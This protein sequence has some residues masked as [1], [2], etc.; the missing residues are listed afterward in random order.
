MKT[1]LFIIS[2]LFA[3]SAVSAQTS[4]KVNVTTAGTLSDYI[5]TTECKSLT[6]LTVTGN[7]DAR[8]FAFM[9]DRLEVLADLDLSGSS[10]RAYQGTSGTV[11]GYE[12]TYNANEIPIYAFYNPFYDTYKYTL[13]SFKF[14]YLTSSIGYLAFYYCSSLTG[15]LTIPASVKQIL[16]YTFYG[17][18]SLTDF[19]VNTANTKFSS[20][21]GVLFNKN[22]DTL[23]VCPSGKAG[24]FSIPTTVKHISASAF[25]NTYNLTSITL[26]AGLK[27]IGTYGFCYS[28]GISGDLNL[29]STLTRVEY[30]AFYGCWNLTG[31]VTIPASLTEIGSYC[32][33]ESNNL[34]SFTVSSS[35]SKY[36]SR[37]GV[38]YSKNID[39]LFICP[40]TKAGTFTIP[41]SVKALGLYA[42]NNCTQLSGTMTITDNISFIGDGAFYKTTSLSNF[43]VSPANST[44]VAENGVLFSKDKSLLIACPPA[45]TGSYQMPLT[46]RKIGTLAFAFC[47]NLTGLMNIPA[48]VNKMGGYAFYGC[49]NIDGFNVE[50]GNSRYA[51]SE[52]VLFNAQMD[53]VLICPYKKSGLYSLPQTVKHIDVSAFSGCDLLTEVELPSGLT[54]IGNYSFENCT[55]LTRVFIPQNVNIIGYAAFNNCT[56][57]KEFAINK[58]EPIY[59]D[60]YALNLIDKATCRL[61][62]PIGSKSLYQN[63]PYWKEFANIV[64]TNFSTDVSLN[65]SDDYGIVRY[66]GGIIVN[67]LKEKDLVRVYSV[68]GQLI[69]SFTAIQHNENIPLSQRGVVLIQINNR[70]IKT[71]Y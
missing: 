5:T 2:F 70:T 4:K 18:F 35:N 52:G 1:K 59:V 61:L 51:S 39:T 41:T 16:D 60:Y 68:N 7:I 50:T 24:A 58:S 22:R 29:P 65:K 40:P 15:T 14:P 45:K 69:K 56:G 12:T 62:V 44:F 8:D 11:S 43:A 27:S 38:F 55:G 23:L 17:C 54:S 57:L 31:N 46:V 36:A 71:V 42:F 49:N 9:R 67:G 34:K 26:P 28:G 53:T 20:Y 3:L 6:Q 25:E 19:S 33:F 47:N 63:A 64:E 30:G 13:K 37:D 32:F 48:G 10:I 21:E 66:I